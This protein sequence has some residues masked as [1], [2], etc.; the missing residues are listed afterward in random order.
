[1]TTPD[2]DENNYVAPTNFTQVVVAK[3]FNLEKLTNEIR[4]KAPNAEVSLVAF[5]APPFNEANP[6]TLTVGTLGEGPTLDALNTI[7]KKHKPGA[8]GADTPPQATAPQVNADPAV[9]EA[10]QTQQSQEQAPAPTPAPEPTPAPAS[11]DPAPASTDPTPAPAE[12]APAPTEP[13][14][15]D[16][17]PAPAPTDAPPAEPTA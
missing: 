5:A 7:V 12:P 1:M 16:P 11:T 6:A 2:L 10:E 17:T 13:A 3:E 4:V 15:A 8:G 14:P 9:V